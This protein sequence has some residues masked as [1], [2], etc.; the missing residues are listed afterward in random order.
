MNR[1][2]H[3]VDQG[4]HLDRLQFVQLASYSVAGR[5]RI[6]SHV[7]LNNFDGLKWSILSQLT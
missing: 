2:H 1:L 5:V 6:K 3:A 4:M 7:K